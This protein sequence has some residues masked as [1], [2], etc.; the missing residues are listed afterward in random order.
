MLDFSYNISPALKDYLEKIDSLRS[1]I[2]SQ[3]ISPKQELKI[4]FES[5]IERIYYI[6]LLSGI[7]L[8]KS[9]VQKT[10]MNPFVMGKTSPVTA[11][12]LKQS[13]DYISQEWLSQPT[14]TVH[15]KHIELLYSHLRGGVHIQDLKKLLDYIS[16]QPDHPVIQAGVIFKQLRKPNPQNLNIKLLSHLAMLLFFYKNGFDIKGFFVLEKEWYKNKERFTTMNNEQSTNLTLWLEYFAESVANALENLLL[17]LTS[18]YPSSNLIPAAFVDLN[19]RQKSILTMLDNPSAKI[20]NK[21][22]ANAFKVSQIT[23][24]RDLSRLS[25][26]GLILTH[27]RGRSVYYTKI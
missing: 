18:S 5:H 7:E 11:L 22:V 17:Q 1:S 13:I 14:Q 21:K 9:E 15:S 26:L 12:N 19:D 6:C 20:S 23:A 25:H 27:G 3:V 24:S 2:L 8:H 16:A 10:L 4:R